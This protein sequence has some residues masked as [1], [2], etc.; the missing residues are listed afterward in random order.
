MSP[1]LA[2]AIIV[3]LDVAIVIAI[4]SILGWGLRAHRRDL[5]HGRFLGRR[6]VA[7]RRRLD[8]AVPA[9][10]ERRRGQRRAGGPLTA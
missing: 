10:G 9:H 4:L 7:D 2:V 6:R 1:S 5:L 8:R 3:L